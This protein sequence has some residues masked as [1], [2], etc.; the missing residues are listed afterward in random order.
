M[1]TTYLIIAIVVVLLVLLLLVYNSLV[2][3]RNKVKE[4]LATMDV[5]LKKRFD[6]VPQLVEVVRGYAGH[7][8]QVL[9]DVASKRS[10]AMADGDLARRLN[11]EQNISEALKRIFVVAEDY[12]DLKA[13]QSFLRLQEQLSAMEDEIALSR[14]Y[15]NGSVRE[16]NN[17]CQLFPLSLVASAFGFKP[18]P[19]FAVADDRERQAVDVKL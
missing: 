11:G 16:Y 9:Q 5:C 14:R 3:L 18:M 10:S 19:M 6:L 12:P 7:E 17:Q 13:N 1:T 15:Y 8:S 2:R 4:A